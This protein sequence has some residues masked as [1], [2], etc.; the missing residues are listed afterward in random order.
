MHIVYAVTSCSNKVYKQLF[1]HVEKKPAYH[2]QKYHRLLIEGLAAGTK[3]DVVANPP[4]NR[5]VMDKSLVFLPREVEGGANYHY[6]PAIR[7]PI[8]KL[9]CVGAG[10]F[11]KTMF[12]LKNG[13][14]WTWI[15]YRTEHSR[16]ICS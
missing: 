4:V 5:S 6:I 3:V 12:L 1:S 14:K 10:T 2:I 7:N 9:A 8:V 11:F 13:L 15:T 16:E